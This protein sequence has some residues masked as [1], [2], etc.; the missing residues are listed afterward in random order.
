M[1]ERRARVQQDVNHWEFESDCEEDI[2]RSGPALHGLG[3]ITELD[4]RV[5]PWHLQSSN[6]ELF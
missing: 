1:E 3:T 4:L 5:W 2:R 6:Y